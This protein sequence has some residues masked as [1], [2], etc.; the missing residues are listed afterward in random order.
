MSNAVTN[1][2]IPEG[3]YWS[4]LCGM[5]L[6]KIQL[7]SPVT[8]ERHTMAPGA[9]MRRVLAEISPVEND[10]HEAKKLTSEDASRYGSALWSGKLKEYFSWRAEQGLSWWH[11]QE[12]IYPSAANDNSAAAVR[13]AA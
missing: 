13:K 12:R 3:F 8:V 7:G 9:L 11:E 4:K 2:I 1:K 5:A 6:R 10:A